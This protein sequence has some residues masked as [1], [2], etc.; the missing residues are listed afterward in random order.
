RAYLPIPEAGTAYDLTDDMAAISDI[1][2]GSHC[3]SRYWGE[4]QEASW[5]DPGGRL[6]RWDLAAEA[7]NVESFPHTSDTGSKWLTNGDG[8]A[9]ATEGFRF[10][11]CNADDEFA[12][13]IAPVGQGESKGDVFTFSPAVVANNRIDPFNASGGV[14]DAEDRDQFMIALISGSPNDDAIDGG[15]LDNDFHSSIYLIADDHREDPNA[16]FDIPGIGGLTAPGSHAHFMR[17]P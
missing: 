2:V 17:L 5:G 4:M 1:A 12:L 9:G 14:L 3:L 11:A 13:T 7:T 16:G 10:A 8:V 6:Y 15:D